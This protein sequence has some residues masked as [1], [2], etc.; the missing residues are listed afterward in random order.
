M[1]LQSGQNAP[2]G[3]GVLRV[4]LSGDPADQAPSLDPCAFL[5]GAD[6]RVKGDGGFVFY[7]Q[8]RDP[9]GAV[10]F[11]P[12]A[13]TFQVDPARLPAGIE[14]V[15]FALSIDAAV[16]GLR[17]FS[18][19][20]SVL[21]ALHGSGADLRF[22]V[23]TAS[24]SETALIVA[25]IYLRN[26]AWKLRAVGQGFARGVGP[27][28]PQLRGGCQRE[29]STPGACVPADRTAGVAARSDASAN[30]TE[31]HRLDQAPPGVPGKARPG[32][33]EDRGQSQLVPRP[34]QAGMVRAEDRRYRLGP[35]LHGRVGRWG[36]G[37]RASA[38]KQ[39]R[40]I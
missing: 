27:A 17:S 11:D 10:T 26:G 20:R 31:A 19:F 38:R 23:A 40:G 3:A 14:R 36:Q 34:G 37:R 24:M 25:E 18:Q 13:M 21:L 32:V 6:G 39:L 12:V 29:G 9:A 30:A 33:R 16:A 22:P 7:G 28:R 2:V 35:R 15:V 1:D 5:V 8:P 4:A